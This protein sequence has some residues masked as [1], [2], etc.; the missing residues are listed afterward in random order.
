MNSLGTSVIVKPRKSLIWV[1]TINTA[2]PFVKPM[3]IGRGMNFTAVPRPVN[4][5][6]SRMTPAIIVTM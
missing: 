5:M 4:A 6:T 3:T 1:E 2:M